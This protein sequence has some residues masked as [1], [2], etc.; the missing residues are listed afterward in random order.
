MTRM[1]GVPFLV[2]KEGSLPRRGSGRNELVINLASVAFPAG[3]ILPFGREANPELESVIIWIAAG[4]R[5]R[6]TDRRSR[7]KI[8]LRSAREMGSNIIPSV[9]DGCH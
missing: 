8:R 3:L 5:Y 2:R 4:S 1:T 6:A 9:R 7:T